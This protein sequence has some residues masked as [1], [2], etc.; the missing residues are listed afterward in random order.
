MKIQLLAL[1]FL[2]GCNA[3]SSVEPTQG[4][5]GFDG[6][7][8]ATWRAG[9]TGGSGPTATWEIHADSRAISPPNSLAMTAQNHASEERFNL[10]WSDALSFSSGRLAVAVRSDA[11][12]I[13]QGGGPAWRIQDENNYYI[14]RINPLE[15]NY[16]VYVVKNGVRKQLATARVDIATGLWH[17]LEVEHVG[18]KITC[19]LDGKKQLEATDGSIRGAGGVGLWT[20]ADA[21]TSFDDLS[22]E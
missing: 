7:L 1:A 22:L 2:A 5:I 11:G 6:P 14:C 8:T 10:Y 13:D 21:L 20:K 3:T 9:S 17:K 18:D 4:A 19:W 16:R 12:V 15:A